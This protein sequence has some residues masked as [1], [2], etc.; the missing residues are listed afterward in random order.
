MNNKEN[1]P[2]SWEEEFWEVLKACRYKFEYDREVDYLKSFITRVVQAEREKGRTDI[3]LHVGIALDNLESCILLMTSENDRNNL[4][5]NVL[6]V[7]KD[8]P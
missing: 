8:I 4:V 6:N 2:A 1:P 7:L 5:R 3:L